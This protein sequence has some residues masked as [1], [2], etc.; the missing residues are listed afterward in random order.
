[1]D[2]KISIITISYNAEKEIEK[3]ILSVISLNSATL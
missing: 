3:T 2:P 1:M